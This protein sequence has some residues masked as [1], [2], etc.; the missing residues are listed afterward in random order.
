MHG[1]RLARRDL[2]RAQVLLDRD[3]VVGA[4]LDRRVVGDDH[5]LAAADPAD[6][7]DDAGA[8]DGVVAVLAVHP[9]RGQRAQLEERAARGRAAGRPGRGP[10]ACRGRCASSR[11]ASRPPCRTPRQPLAQLVDELLHLRCHTHEPPRRWLTIANHASPTALRWRDEALGKEP[12]RLGDHVRGT[13][14]P[15]LV[16]RVTTSEEQ[17]VDPGQQRDNCLVLIFGTHPRRCRGGSRGTASDAL[18]G[19]A[20]RLACC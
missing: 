1:S 17:A 3:R 7:G 18:G 9:G 11:A 5:A 10:A 12:E 6:A 2:L 13:G 8:R 4:A 19:P 15:D 20:P 16:H 14:P